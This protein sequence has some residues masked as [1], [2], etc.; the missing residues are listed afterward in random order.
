MVIGRGWAVQRNRAPTMEFQPRR[1]NDGFEDYVVELEAVSVLELIIQPDL[2][3]REA[4]A[5]LASWRIG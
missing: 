3:H 1:L 2:G 5:T 4:V